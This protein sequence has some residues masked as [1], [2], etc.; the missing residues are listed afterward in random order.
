MGSLLK[1]VLF[2]SPVLFLLLYYVIN[3]QGKIDVQ[4]QKEDAVFEREWNEFSAEFT[5]D[6]SKRQ[7]Y[8]DRARQAEVK[9]QELEKKEKEKQEKSEKLESE[10]DKVLQD[11]ETQEELEKRFKKKLQ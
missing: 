3:Q 8:A 11:K 5:K 9:R 1:I 6:Q 2:T 7:I 4:M 10:M